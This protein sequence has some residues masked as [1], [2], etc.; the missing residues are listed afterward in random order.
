MYYLV[1]INA[2]IINN[3]MEIKLIHIILLIVLLIWIYYS[4]KNIINIYKKN[5]D[6]DIMTF[7]LVGCIIGFGSI[8]IISI[9]DWSFLFI[10]LFKL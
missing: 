10:S 8:G 6:I 2:T 9:I 5:D 4:I 7:M 1:H 3:K